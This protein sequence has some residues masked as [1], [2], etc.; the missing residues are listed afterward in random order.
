MVVICTAL[1]LMAW[2]LLSCFSRWRFRKKSKS[3]EIPDLAYHSTPM[4]HVDTSSGV[5]VEGIL[6][7]S[8]GGPRLDNGTIVLHDST[9]KPIHPIVLAPNNPN[10]RSVTGS[11]A[12]DQT[13]ESTTEYTGLHRTDSALLN[14][15]LGT[16]R[17]EIKSQ[18]PGSKIGQNNQYTPSTTPEVVQF[19]PSV[20]VS[21]APPLP[22]NY[23]NYNDHGNSLPPP[24]APPPPSLQQG[25]VIKQN[26]VPTCPTSMPSSPNSSVVLTPKSYR[27]QQMTQQPVL[28]VRP[29]EM[30][31]HLANTSVLSNGT[32]S[33]SMSTV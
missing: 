4:A 15:H 12:T 7:A 33:S 6:V 3:I 13:T 22:R 28:V 20:S 29:N 1:I 2:L 21:V 8:N 32:T 10:G 17:E 11:P 16:P 23:G 5:F 31:S 18:T 26:T 14:K 19:D 24:A 9:G 27:R 30:T 25:I